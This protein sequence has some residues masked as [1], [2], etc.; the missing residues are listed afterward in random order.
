MMS[1]KKLYYRFLS[2]ILPDKNSGKRI[3]LITGARQTGKTTLA[4]IKY[5]GLRYINLDLMENR[6]ILREISAL[7]WHRDIGEAVIDEAQKEASIFEK[8]KYAYDEDKISFQVLLGSSQIMLLK[9]IRES[10]AGRIWIYELWPLMMCE[11]AE[12]MTYPLLDSVIKSTKLDKVLESISS[13]LFEQEA[14]KLRSIEDHILKWG[15]M[16]A[17][18]HIERDEEKKKW[19]K[20]YQYTYLERDL[21]DLARLEYLE[22]F[23]K[24]QKLVA[25]RSGSILNYSDLARDSGISVDTAKR[26]FEYLRISYQTI[27]IQPYYRNITSSVIK[28]PKIYISDI[29][30]LRSLTGIYEAVTGE[31][32]ETMVVTEVY[33]WVN[34]MQIPCSIFYYRTRSGLEVDLLIETEKGLI[35]FEIKGRQEVD[36]VDIRSMKALAEKLGNQWI[37]GI[38]IYKGNQIKRLSDSIWAVPSWRLFV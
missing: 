33:K 15:G 9:K 24:F 2:N 6:E 13:V 20:D 28:T 27:F 18:I 5:S 34:T 37:G 16:P 17:L 10:L 36:S 8:I 14:L 3:I 4:K 25:L 1:E 23:R 12:S 30:L 38:V 26:Y 19:L 22:P 32:Y 11:M 21:S 31:I 35:A 29:G 7:N